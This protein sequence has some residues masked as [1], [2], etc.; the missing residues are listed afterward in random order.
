MDDPEVTLFS[1]EFLQTNACGYQETVSVDKTLDFLTHNELARSFTVHSESRDDIGSHTV[2]VSSVISVPD[3]HTMST[4][5]DHENEVSF[6]VN[7]LD[8]CNET[9][10]IDFSI[11]NIYSYFPSEV[12]SADLPVVADT[13]GQG[14]PDRSDG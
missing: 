11:P 8:P 12:K 6:T 1:Y 2:T 14:R 7:I 9:E 5:T 4:F 13:K 10:L 3:D